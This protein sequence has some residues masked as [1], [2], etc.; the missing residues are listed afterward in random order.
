MGKPKGSIGETKFKILAI[1]HHNEALGITSYGY[2]IWAI[3]NKKY[4]SSLSEDGLRNV[5]HHLKGLRRLGLIKKD[6]VQIIQGAPKRRIYRLTRKGR[7][8]QEKFEKYM[9]PLKISG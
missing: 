2:G 7:R 8:L 4:F 6:A 1:L 5:Y 3:L 9:T